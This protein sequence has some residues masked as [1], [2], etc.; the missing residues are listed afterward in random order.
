MH[1][2]LLTGHLNP[3]SRAERENI[4]RQFDIRKEIFLRWKRGYTPD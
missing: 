3:V 1:T 4:S 2:L